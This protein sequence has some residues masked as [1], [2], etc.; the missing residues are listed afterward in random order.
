MTVTSSSRSGS[1]WNIPSLSGYLKCTGQ[2]EEENSTSQ[3]KTCT[4]SKRTKGLLLYPISKQSYINSVIILCSCMLEKTLFRTEP[5]LHPAYVAREFR[6]GLRN[7]SKYKTTSL[8]CK[9][10]RLQLWLGRGCAVWGRLYVTSSHTD[11]MLL[12]FCLPV[13]FISSLSASMGI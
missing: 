7:Q 2:Q 13:S 3:E 11:L 10:Q 1:V 5:V 4:E 9:S 8:I 6:V 12:F